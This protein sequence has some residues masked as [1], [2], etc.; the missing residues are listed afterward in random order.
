MKT[1]SFLAAL[2]VLVGTTA[3]ANDPGNTRIAV[4]GQTN[5]GVF[6][7]VY[8]G[9]SVGNVKLTIFNKYKE[10]VF[11]ESREVSGFIRNVNFAKMAPGEYT[12]QIADKTGKESKTVV[13]SA[14][15]SS[16]K[17]VTVSKLEETDKYLLAVTNDAPETIKVKIFDGESNLVHSR[18][19]TIDRSLKLVYF[20]K[21]V[22][23]VPTFEITDRNGITRTIAGY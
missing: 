12:I 8:K 13:Y 20:L 21:N 15:T 2:I 9:E 5:A 18:E 11:E 19:M 16:V 4:Y 10:V 3:F 22:E 17:E 1:T 6:K 14:E 7:V 23:G